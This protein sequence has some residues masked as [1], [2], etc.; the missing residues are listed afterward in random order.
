MRR[1]LVLALGLVLASGCG[2]PHPTAP[3]VPSP[4]GA[5]SSHPTAPEVPAGFNPAAVPARNDDGLETRMDG[6]ETWVAGSDVVP[7]PYRSMGTR[8]ASSLCSWSIASAAV[9]TES[10]GG[11]ADGPVRPTVDAGVSTGRDVPIRIV[12]LPG[13]RLQ[14]GGCD[15][16]VYYGP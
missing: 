8:F 9:E 7:G 3:A 6:D 1:I 5:A 12:L 4:A 10:G 14:S 11:G 13:E 16:W 2:A 15:T